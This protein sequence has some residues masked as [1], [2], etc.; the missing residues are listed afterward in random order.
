MEQRKISILSL[1]EL[2][3]LKPPEYLI[4]RAIPERGL[5][6]LVAEPSSKKT[7]L[8][9]H[10]AACIATG[11]PFFDT[12]VKQGKVVYVAAEGQAGI[13]KRIDA[14]EIDHGVAIPTNSFSV[15]PEAVHLNNSESLNALCVNLAAHREKN[16]AIDLLIID[17]LNRS[18]EGDENA[19][20]DMSNFVRGCTEIINLLGCAIMLLHHPSKGGTGGARGHSALNGAADI[21]LEIKNGKKD[22]FTVKMNAKPPKDDEPAPDLTLKAKIIDLSHKHGFDTQGEPITSLVLEKVDGG[23]EFL[24]PIPKAKTTQQRLFETVPGI[25]GS[26]Q[27]TR[28]GIAKGLECVIEDVNS[29]TLSRALTTLLKDGVLSQP[30]HGLYEVK[31][32]EM[33]I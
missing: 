31:S 11:R 5:I 24:P 32:P 27:L 20:K 7:F 8:A 26:G 30:S 25:I 2:R 6:Y 3:A 4:P 23:M 13:C 16:G 21:G 9:I 14:W 18:L 15:I 28:D 17:T 19:A 33:D 29:R 12:P 10:M 22:I 1:D